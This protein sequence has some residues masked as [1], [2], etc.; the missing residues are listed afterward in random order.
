MGDDFIVEPAVVPNPAGDLRAIVRRPPAGLV[1]GLVFVDGSGCGGLEEWGRWP[2]WISGCGVAVLAHDKPGCGTSPGDWRTQSFADR[3]AEALAAVE[4]LRKWPG[5]DPRGIGLIGWS[6]G[7]WV[8]LLAA[9]TAPAAVERVVTISGPGVSMA[10]QERMRIDSW[11]RRDGV[12]G[13]DRAEG[14]AWVDERARRLRAGESAEQVVAA[15]L[16]F[17]GKP[18]YEVVSLA[19]AT[20]ATTEFFARS[21]DIDPAELLPKLRCPVLT[22]FGGADDAV[23][24]ETSVARIAAARPETGVEVFPGADHSLFVDGALAPGF[25]PKLTAFLKQPA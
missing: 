9:S 20:P 6:Q 15:Q 3:A 5:V 10:E 11:L 22:L 4:V 25:L 18:W 23:P 2:E 16:E 8:S 14:M 17:A 24:V 13:E 21:M 12:G 19:T 7:G 1:P